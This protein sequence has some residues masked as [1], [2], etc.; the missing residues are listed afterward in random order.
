[1]TWSNLT[2]DLAE[3]F[4]DLTSPSDYEASDAAAEWD[5]WRRERRRRNRALSFGPPTA[6]AKPCQHPGCT[7]TRRRP[8]AGGTAYCDEHASAEW[9]R[10]R[11]RVATAERRAKLRSTPEGDAQL[12]ADGRRTVAAYRAR[13]PRPRLPCLEPDCREHRVQGSGYRYCEAHRRGR[14]RDRA[15]K[16]A[17]RAKVLADPKRAAIYRRQ[18][19]ANAAAYRARVKGGSGGVGEKV[20]SGTKEGVG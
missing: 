9:V 2:S 12:R 11:N 3:L 8:A 5:A 19:A 10:E 1:M 17:W 4:G 14:E 13:K 7:S 16:A 18:V 15:A 6:E 20:P